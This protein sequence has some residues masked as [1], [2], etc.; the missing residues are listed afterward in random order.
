MVHFDL[1]DGGRFHSPAYE[2]SK[3]LSKIDD[4][5]EIF[6]SVTCSPIAA[7]DVVYHI[8]RSI[9]LSGSNPPTLESIERSLVEKYG[10]P[11]FVAKEGV[12]LIKYNFQ[13]SKDLSQPVKTG[14]SFAAGLTYLDPG[15]AKKAR[16]ALEANVGLS[17]QITIYMT[18]D[19]QLRTMELDMDDFT[20]FM[21]AY[22]TMVKWAEISVAEAQAAQP[23]PAKA[24]KL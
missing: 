4:G 19:R 2:F 6:L 5:R 13:L 3:T 21:F 15:N 16:Q 7:G 22:D 18:A 9:D 10:E 11:S 14:R 17:L 24:P 8:D 20:R 12:A 23:P 1:R